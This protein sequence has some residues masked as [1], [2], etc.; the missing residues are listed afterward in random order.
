[1][2]SGESGSAVG[3]D[4]VAAASVFVFGCDVAD[5]LVQ[6][7][8]VMESPDGVEFSFQLC[9]VFDLFEVRVFGL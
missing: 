8:R 1:V 4:G 2:G 5:A 6:A 9:R 3:A 7:H